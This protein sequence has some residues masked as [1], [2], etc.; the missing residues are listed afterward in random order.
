MLI[1]RLAMAVHA[2]D[3]LEALTDWEMIP[4]KQREGYVF[5][6]RAV[7]AHLASIGLPLAAIEAVRKG[8]AKVLPR[9]ITERQRDAW[10]NDGWVHNEE[11]TYSMFYD[12][13]PEWKK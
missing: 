4:D 11:R 2:A 10:K 9:D 12:A 6:A 5:V 13:A 1:D 8:E 7:L 3:G